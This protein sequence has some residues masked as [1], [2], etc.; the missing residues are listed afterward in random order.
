MNTRAVICVNTDSPIRCT[1]YSPPQTQEAR[2][3]AHARENLVRRSS[4]PSIAMKK[5]GIIQKIIK[6]YEDY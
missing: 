3:H 5:R 4:F 6:V 1:D 2:L